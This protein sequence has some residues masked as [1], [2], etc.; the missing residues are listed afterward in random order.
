MRNSPQDVHKKLLGRFGERRAVRYLKEHGY[1]ILKINYKTPFGE[2]DIVARDGDTVV[3]CE[4]KTRQSDAFGTPA[5]AVDFHKRKRYINIARA[6]LM[7]AGEQNI[8]FDVLEVTDE[9]IHH[10]LSAFEA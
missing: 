5:E 6:F 2:A 7:R 10:I 9:G 1:K 4:V 3:F 8:R